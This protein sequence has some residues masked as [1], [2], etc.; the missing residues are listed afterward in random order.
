MK[1]KTA[2]DNFLAANPEAKAIQAATVKS[3]C[4]RIGTFRANAEK[5][6][7]AM[8][9]L[10]NDAR[11]IGI[12]VMELLD[13]LPGKQM[14]I[15]FWHQFD[16]IFVDQFGQKIT[17]DNLKMFVRIAQNNPKPVEDLQMALSWRQPLFAAAGFDLIGERPGT[18]AK[19][20]NY[21]NQLFKVL[22]AAKISGVLG[23]LE[24]DPRFGPL[25]EW[26]PERRKSAWLQIEPIYKQLEELKH[27]LTALD[28]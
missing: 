24:A 14:T 23:R 13:S 26:P 4:H 8:V 28:V 16:G 2:R 20:V 7:Q 1:T 27:K 18:N 9:H 12:F 5:A 22:D 17:L 6:S 25:D 15:D 19:D 21:Y 11:E 3:I 10:C